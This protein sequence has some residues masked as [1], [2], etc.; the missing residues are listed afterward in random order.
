[1]T[2]LEKAKFLET[3]T[4]VQQAHQSFAS[5]GQSKLC[6]TQS[7]VKHHF[8]AIVRNAKGELV[9]LD[10]MRDIGPRVLGECTEDN[11]LEKAGA[12]IMKR[13]MNGYITESLAV[14]ALVR[15]MD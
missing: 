2:P 1:M 6:E 9:E 14:S 4:K 8:I 12:E 7:D 10:G 13:V 15:A 3:F 11:F 5:E